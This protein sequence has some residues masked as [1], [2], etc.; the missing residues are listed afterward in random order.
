MERDRM[1]PSKNRGIGVLRIE[2]AQTKIEKDKKKDVKMGS[3]PCLG[4]HTVK[5][6]AIR[7]YVFH[8]NIRHKIQIRSR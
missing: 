7:N 1:V 8:I 3:V 4:C 2:D 6:V 5:I